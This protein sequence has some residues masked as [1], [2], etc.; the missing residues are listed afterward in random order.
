MEFRDKLLP[1]DTPVVDKDGCRTYEFD[2]LLSTPEERTLVDMALRRLAH[3]LLSRNGD[4]IGPINAQLLLKHLIERDH[5]E[6]PI[7]ISFH[8]A[9]R[10]ALLLRLGA[11]ATLGQAQGRRVTE[12]AD[13]IEHEVVSR[14]FLHQ[15]DTV[16]IDDLSE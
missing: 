13:Q 12:M 11:A 10:F 16:T 14:Q 6:L 2:V 7:P 8:Q 1:D 5:D 4:G 3:N 9:E 15:L